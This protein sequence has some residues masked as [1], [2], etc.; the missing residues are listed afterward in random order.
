MKSSLNLGLIGNCRI[1]AL[2]DERG[3]IVWTCL[4]R[5]DGDPVFCSLLAE[6]PD[7]EGAGFCVV[8]LLDQVEASQSYLPNTAVLSTR[9][10]DSRGAVI[11]ITDF[12]PRFHQYGRT[13]MPMMIIRK[14]RRV[15]GNPRICVRVRPL[16][17]YGGQQCI[18]THGSHHIRYVAPSWILRLTTDISVTAVLQE[19]PFFLET[20]ATLILGPD[21]TIPDAIDDLSRRFLDET[22][23]S[24]RDWVRDLSI[25]F[26]WQE[27][28]IRAAITL[29]LNTF[30]DTG[31]IIAAMTTSIP[32]AP[33]SGRNWDYRYCWLRD[34]YFVVNALN[35]LSTTNTMERYLNYLI[36]VVAGTPDGRIQPVYGIDGKARLEEREVAS[37]QG[38]R[39]MGP[40]R[41]GNQACEQIQ[42][43]VYGSAIL[44]VAHVFFDRR[45]A[46]RGGVALF[47]RLEPLGEMAIAV[48]D[49]PDSGPWETRNTLRV[50]TFSS[51]MC[52]AAC[53][54]LARI[55]VYIGL[56]D[57]AA[58]WRT[59]ADK[60]Q[61]TICRRAWNEKKRAFAASFDGDSL[62][63]SL[64][65]IH[66]TGFLPA[67]DPRFAQTIAAIERE[68]RRGN[69]IYR[70]VE[71]DDFGVPE[72]AFVVCTFWY[73]YA[74]AAVNRVDEARL[75]FENLLSRR[76]RHGLLAEHIDPRTGDPW[77]NFVQTY[78]MVG[79]INSAIRLS[80]RWDSAF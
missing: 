24:W 61:A 22:I 79:L 32:E 75:L 33:G 52:W 15:S 46:H 3:E 57:R 13:F 72:N 19:L 31:A 17:E 60:I 14:I 16:S 11:E 67:D 44:A 59:Q 64:L 5:F 7:G 69:Y 39:G 6:H 70:Y 50:H 34:S 28:V 48:H 58:Y 62:D 41:I 8:E 42:H 29:K 2:I 26:E 56:A 43:D 1:G 25:P 74:L 51:I 66:D 38:Y 40:V 76:N 12:S 37:L 23:N 45:L 77:G 4:P 27:E 49:Q 55:A 47:T 65:L 9:L 18:V 35:R 36:N 63:A 71:N 30:Q 73:I 21:E 78:S 80:R 68:L 53:D 20:T 10:T 54:R